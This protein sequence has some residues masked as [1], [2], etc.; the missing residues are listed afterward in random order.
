MHKEFN[1]LNYWQYLL[2][3]VLLLTM[4]QNMTLSL[5]MM[6]VYFRQFLIFLPLLLGAGLLF[7]SG[8]LD[9]SIGGVISLF[10]SLQACLY[11][12]SGKNFTL[13]VLLLVM[14]SVLFAVF[15]TWIVG[16]F[17]D[18][19]PVFTFIQLYIYSGFA[20]MLY[21]FLSQDFALTVL[22]MPS[23]KIYAIVSMIAAVFVYAFLKYTTYGRSLYIY[24]RSQISAKREGM[25]VQRIFGVSFLIVFFLLA[26]YTILNSFRTGLPSLYNSFF[27][28]YQVIA[29]VSLLN[30]RSLNEKNFVLR[31]VNSTICIVFIESILQTLISSNTGK[32]LVYGIVLLLA[33]A[34][35]GFEKK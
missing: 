31:V 26:L 22:P 6:H 27:L 20:E 35:N 2:S 32:N 19:Y 29:G 3:A 21:Y 17:S 5:H 23:S 34:I 13:T 30:K 14:F 10:S 16:K 4:L 28:E 25:K 8:Y 1:F 7:L 33:Y 12:W 15:Q 11:F 24:G 18:I 9:L